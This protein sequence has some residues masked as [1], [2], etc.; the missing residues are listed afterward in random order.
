MAGKIERAYT[1]KDVK[2]LDCALVYG[3]E[4]KITSVEGGEIELMLA[5]SNIKCLSHVRTKQ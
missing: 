5:P 3:L 2:A 1:P 4:T